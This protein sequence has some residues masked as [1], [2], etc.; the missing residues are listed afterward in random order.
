MVPFIWR[1]FTQKL[2]LL[3]RFFLTLLSSLHNRP[4]QIIEYENR[5]RQ[6]STPDKV[7]RYFA[8]IQVPH[9]HGYESYEPFM[10]PI[11]FLTS[12]TPGIKQPEGRS[13]RSVLS[14]GNCSDLKASC[15]VLDTLT[16]ALVALFYDFSSYEFLHIDR[17]FKIYWNVTNPCTACVSNTKCPDNW[18]FRL[19]ITFFV[20]IS[21]LGL[22]QYKKYD[23]KVSD[24]SSRK[25]SIESSTIEH[26]EKKSLFVS[27]LSKQSQCIFWSLQWCT[28]L[29][30]T[31]WIFDLQQ[32]TL[33]R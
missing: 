12:M 32:V 20:S 29:I 19:L 7:F 10:T 13:R 14:R 33:P 6:Y 16:V 22:D 9:H 15:S 18:S 21:G 31:E 3:T 8:T 23:P 2:C 24:E 1:I 28:Q 4:I 27:I 5:I 11:D 17:T 25:L 26:K 30:P